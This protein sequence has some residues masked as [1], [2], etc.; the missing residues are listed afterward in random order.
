MAPAAT[1]SP[2]AQQAVCDLDESPAAQPA[3]E[4]I[5]PAK[6]CLEDIKTLPAADLERLVS[7]ANARLA[8]IQ[9][10]TKVSEKEKLIQEMAEIAEKTDAGTVMPPVV[11]VIS[12]FASSEVRVYADVFEVT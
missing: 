9:E 8:S 5:D 1:E 7:E 12:V 11:I 2:A 10:G 6:A 4:Q 3:E